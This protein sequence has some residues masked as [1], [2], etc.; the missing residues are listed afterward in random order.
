M[1]LLQDFSLLPYNTFRVNVMAKYF[2]LL[3]DQAEIRYFVEELYPRYAPCLI[4]G[5]G[6]NILFTKDFDGLVV[7]VRNRGME[8]E[9]VTDLDFLV[10]VEAGTPWN[11]VV[12]FCVDRNMSG[13]ENLALIPGNT[14]S[15]PI[16]NIGA[17]GV[18]LK[19]VVYQVRGF[20]LHTGE[21]RVLSREDCRFG[22]R[23]SIFKRELKGRF[24]I[25]S[26]TIQLS[27]ERPVKDHYPTLRQELEKRGCFHP[28]ASDIRDA[29]SH[30]RKSRLPDPEVTGNA[31]S[32]FKNPLVSAAKFE[33][34]K[35]HYPS[36][37]AYPEPGNEYK[38]PA[39]WLIEQCGWKGKR[40]G[41]AGVHDRQAL[42]LV[43]HGGASGQEILEL[44]E[45]IRSSVDQ[46]FGITLEFEVNI[47]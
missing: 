13:I 28:S 3:R 29:V 21:S 33:D 1:T 42:V 5:G 45:Q 14:G 9:A 36:L 15:G 20:D 23:D 37:S 38:I 25:S 24:L 43:N 34:L 17:Y 8:V 46:E 40:T 35:L 4:L 7:A 26:V 11:E 44:A 31:G 6:S 18:E 22:Y 30:I 19:D 39:G 12:D 27:K 41:N 10:T 47:I 16:Q 32:F 2:T